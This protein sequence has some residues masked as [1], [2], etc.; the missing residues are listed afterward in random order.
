MMPCPRS[1]RW[2]AQ[3][4]VLYHLGPRNRAAFFL[5]EG[6]SER[7]GPFVVFI[8]Q[9][10][11]D[12]T[13]PFAADQASDGRWRDPDAGRLNGK[14]LLMACSMAGIGAYWLWVVF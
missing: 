10:Q 12:A 6:C 14:L 9:I 4:T 1:V 7:G 11:R 2:V 13:R 8:F 5:I 3:K